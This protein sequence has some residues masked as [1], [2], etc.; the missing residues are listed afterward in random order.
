MQVEVNE[1][2]GH[3]KRFVV[4]FKI[5]LY[6]DHPVDQYHTHVGTYPVLPFHVITDFKFSLVAIYN[7]DS[8]I[9]AINYKIYFIYIYIC[10]KIYIYN[11]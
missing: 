2:H 7:L 9:I 6:L 11:T 10:N 5:F 4:K 1:F 8:N 3:I